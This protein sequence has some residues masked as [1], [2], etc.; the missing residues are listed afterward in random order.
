MEFA[1]LRAS[2]AFASYVPSRFMCLRALR[3][4]VLAGLACLRA[5]VYYAPSRLTGLTHASYRRAL[6]TL[7]VRVK[8][9]LGW[10]CS[11]AKAFHFPRIIKGTTNCVILNKS[12]NLK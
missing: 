7:L 6:H 9:V 4:F 2:R 8:I 10:I 3:A 1:K 5:F 12:F 11:P